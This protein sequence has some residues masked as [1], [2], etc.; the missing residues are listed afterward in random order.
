MHFRLANCR[1]KAGHRS[2]SYLS[3]N[4]EPHGKSTPAQGLQPSCPI[5]RRLVID[6][7]PDQSWRGGG[8]KPKDV[9]ER[10]ESKGATG[11]ENE[12]AMT[13][14]QRLVT[15]TALFLIHVEASLCPPSSIL[16]SQLLSLDSQGDWL[17][18]HRSYI[19]RQECV[20]CLR[21]YKRKQPT[22]RTRPCVIECL[23]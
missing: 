22:S 7:E 17:M 8:G 14:V 3:G 12:S 18:A 6:G 23:E 16:R 20:A 19:G 5:G 13:S 15:P 2:G 9:K 1:R 21:R 4:N 10:E 11:A